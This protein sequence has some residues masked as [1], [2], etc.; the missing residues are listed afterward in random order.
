[1]KPAQSSGGG[2]ELRRPD[3]ERVTF[4]CKFQAAP[5]VDLQPV[6]DTVRQL[7]DVQSQIIE[8]QQK[9]AEAVEVVRQHLDHLNQRL[10]TLGLQIDSSGVV[11]RITGTAKLPE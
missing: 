9:L 4:T 2:S 6:V 10:V 11:G 8:S 1:V 3:P 5:A 7:S